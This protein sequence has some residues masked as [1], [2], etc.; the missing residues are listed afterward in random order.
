MGHGNGK[1]LEMSKKLSGYGKWCKATEAVSYVIPFTMFHS[2]A[3]S[4]SQIHNLVKLVKIY[5]LFFF[6]YYQLF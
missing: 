4:K 3:T 6:Q 1:V 5:S 2:Q